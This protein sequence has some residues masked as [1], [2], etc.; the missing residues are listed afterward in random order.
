M[1]V[2]SR[3]K[4]LDQDFSMSTELEALLCANVCAARIFY[5]EKIWVSQARGN[6]TETEGSKSFPRGTYPP[7]FHASI[8]SQGCSRW[9]GC[10]LGA[11][12]GWYVQSIAEIP[13]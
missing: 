9:V 1:S 3:G 13:L 5:K 11:S 12:L 7:S 8:Y 6:P 4:T 2:L 10:T